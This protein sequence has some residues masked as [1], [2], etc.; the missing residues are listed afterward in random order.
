MVTKKQVENFLTTFDDA[1]SIFESGELRVSLLPGRK[2]INTGD[3]D[4]SGKVIWKNVIDQ[5]EPCNIFIKAGKGYVRISALDFVT[6]FTRLLKNGMACGV[7][8]HWASYQLNVVSNALGLKG[9]YA[10]PFALYEEIP[11]PT[12]T[13]KKK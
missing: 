3:R 5:K 10:S 2:G 12:K 7:I 11:E 13:P 9:E 4:A 8:D 1:M 6:M